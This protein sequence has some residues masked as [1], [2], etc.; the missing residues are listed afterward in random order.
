[1][2]S[3]EDVQETLSKFLNEVDE[4]LQSAGVTHRSFQKAW[5][6]IQELS[7]EERTFCELV[8]SLGIAPGQASE[9]IS[10]AVEKLFETLGPR[11]IRDFCLAV[12]PKEMLSAA[13][14]AEEL[15]MKLHQLPN[16]KIDAL[17]KADLPPENLKAPSWRRGIA[18][19]KSLREKFGI[20]I[21]D[22]FGASKIFELLNIDLHQDCGLRRNSEMH[23][24]GAIDR[25]GDTAK[26]ALLPENVSHRRFAAGRAAYLA[27]VSG[28]KAMRLMTSA[29]T[30]DQQASRQF[31]AEILV[32][33]AYLKTLAQSKGKL[34]YD[35]IVEI[36]RSRGA[37]PDVAFKQAYN[38]GI[39]V[40]RI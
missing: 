22:E 38:A 18:A 15:K 19:A 3:T 12:R 17:L 23:F 33:Q 25:D 10:D 16:T 36:A 13:A 28:D 11:A 31:A 32:P 35:H 6:A 8:G 20:D 29:L 30:R 39:N 24:S 5:Q 7:D 40:A 21:K 37:M 27:W 14:N 1:M 26:I 9:E 4:R 34:G 2:N